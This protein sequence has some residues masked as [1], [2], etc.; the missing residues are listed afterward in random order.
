[1]LDSALDPATRCWTL[2][3]DGVLG[4]VAAAGLR[5]VAGARPPGRDDAARTRSSRSP[6]PSDTV[7]PPSATRR[8]IDVLAAGAVLW[9]RRCATAPRSRWCTGRATTTGR[10]PK[11]KLDA[12]ETMPFAAVARGGRGDRVTRCRLGAAA[13]RRAVPRWPRARSWCGT[14]RREAGGGAFTPNHETDELRWLAPDARRRPADLPARPSTCCDRFTELGPAAV[15]AAA[16]PARQGRQPRAVGRR[17]RRCARCPGPAGSRPARWPSC[18]RCSARTGCAPRR[19]CAAGRRSS[20]WPSGS[21]CRSSTSRCS[22]RT[23]TGPTRAAGLAR[24]REL[25]GSPG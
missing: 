10:F 23:A 17:R 7:D 6:T 5:R 15:G 14:G 3:A 25:A 4:A 12:G 2:H 19:R 22:A 20:R 13:R 18:C 16:G 9:R 1:M 8:G 21:A 24:L 11:G